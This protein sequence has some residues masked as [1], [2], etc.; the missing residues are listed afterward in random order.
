MKRTLA[1]AAAGLAI[2]AGGVATA[3]PAGA[4]NHPGMAFSFVE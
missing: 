2:L 1:A 3:S 4:V